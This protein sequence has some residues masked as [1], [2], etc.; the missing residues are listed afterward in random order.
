MCIQLSRVRIVSSKKVRVRFVLMRWFR[1][2]CR[3][4]DGIEIILQAGKSAIMVRKS[5]ARE[6][7]FNFVPRRTALAFGIFFPRSGF[8]ATTLNFS[9]PRLPRI[10][11]DTP[12]F[13]RVRHSERVRL[14]TAILRFIQRHETQH[15]TKHPDV[16]SRTPSHVVTRKPAAVGPTNRTHTHD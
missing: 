3:R 1:K 16:L 15:A 7:D 11:Q 12:V 5:V 6:V 14:S 9:T 4:S 13:S 2:S 8:L 10:V